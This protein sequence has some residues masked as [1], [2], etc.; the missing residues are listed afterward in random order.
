MQLN[1]QNLI[2]DHTWK[3]ISTASYCLAVAFG[4]GEISSLIIIE[5]ISMSWQKKLPQI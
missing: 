1:I 2:Y 3:L 5:S 4:K